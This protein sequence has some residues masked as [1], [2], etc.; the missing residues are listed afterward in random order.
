MLRFAAVLALAALATGCTARTRAE[1][2][3]ERPTLEV[4]PVP[5]RVID[6]APP[7]PPVALIEPVQELPPP[8]IDPRPAKKSPR[9]TGQR[10][11][12]KPDAKPDTPAAADPAAA[13]P[14]NS[15]PAPE[16]RT[17]AVGD[18]NAARRR[19]QDSLTR[20]QNVLKGIDYQKLTEPR[21]NAYEQAKHMLRRAEEELEKGNYELAQKMAETA[22][23]LVNELQGRV[24]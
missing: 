24:Q 3:I 21:R 16:L 15:Q 22:E 17:P 11:T 1:A 2:P 18:T 5:P 12:Q 7:P 9:D 6:P 23:K 19:I 14:Q 20:A 13:P 4:P 8:T 10:E